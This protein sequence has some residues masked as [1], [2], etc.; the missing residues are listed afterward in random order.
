MLIN[1]IYRIK[2]LYTEERLYGNLVEQN[3]EYRR[4][5]S[6]M[7]N[8]KDSHYSSP[9]GS[10]CL[11]IAADGDNSY[12]CGRYQQLGGY[13]LV[14][15]DRVKHSDQ[16]GGEVAWK[17]EMKLSIDSGATDSE[18]VTSG[19]SLVF[20][21]IEGQ[22]L[23]VGYQWVITGTFR[24]TP[25]GNL[26][27]TVSDIDE[28]ACVDELKINT[29]NINKIQVTK[30]IEKIGEQTYSGKEFQKLIEE[31][32]ASYEEMNGTLEKIAGGWTPNGNCKNI[33]GI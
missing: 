31:I 5:F 17:I 27:F 25:N 28:T 23:D 9:N 11:K 10:W 19:F 6:C 3:V 26:E 30:D 33:L 16:K 12:N 7:D 15:H 4:F 32:M 22:K 18:S 14:F 29:G 21:L 24:C 1:Q 8:T 20:N 2:E 13:K